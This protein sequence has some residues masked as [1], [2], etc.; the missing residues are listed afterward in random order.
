MGDRADR[1][2]MQLKTQKE[3]EDRADRVEMQ[4]KTLQEL[5]ERRAA[6]AAAAS[7]SSESSKSSSGSWCKPTAA[8]AH[9]DGN[10]SPKDAPNSNAQ[11]ELHHC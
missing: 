10:E 5:E 8:D 7:S 6:A 4:L 3:L 1:V 11:G 9:V 2:E